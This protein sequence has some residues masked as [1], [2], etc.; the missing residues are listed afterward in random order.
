MHWQIK[1][2]AWIEVEQFPLPHALMEEGFPASPRATHIIDEEHNTLIFHLIAIYTP[3][4]ETEGGEETDS[5]TDGHDHLNHLSHTHNQCQPDN[6][7]PC[8]VDSRSDSIGEWKQALME[9]DDGW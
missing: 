8:T 3:H 9:K 7:K 1:P 5:R 4:T 6:S 2:W